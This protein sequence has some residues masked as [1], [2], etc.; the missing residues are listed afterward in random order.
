MYKINLK[1]LESTNLVALDTMYLG[2]FIKDKLPRAMDFYSQRVS[3]FKP[4]DFNDPFSKALSVCINEVY[5][6]NEQP[7]IRNVVDTMSQKDWFGKS[8]LSI[9]MD[10]YDYLNKIVSYISSRGAMTIKEFRSRERAMEDAKRSKLLAPDNLNKVIAEIMQSPGTSVDHAI[11]IK[12]YMDDMVGGTEFANKTAD[13]EEQKHLLETLPSEFAKMIGKPRFTF[14][15]HWKLNEFIPVLRPGEKCVMPGCTGEGKSVCAMMFS[16]W[17]AICGK[18]VLVIHMEDSDQTIL[19]RQTVRWIGGTFLELER[20]DPKHR[21]EQM[22]KLR[23]WWNTRGGSLT[24][25]YLAG[26]NIGLIV[27]QIKETAATLEAEDKHLDVVVFDYFQKI[28]FDSGVGSGGNYVNQATA[29]A[30]SLKILA[31]RLKLFMFV[32]SQETPD[33]NGGE[34]ST[35]GKR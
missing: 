2:S 5:Q 32:V 20:G 23:E 22:I 4:Q 26:N 13:W 3:I 30:E 9:D 8:G 16:E 6:K 24:Y 7:T 25:K 12:R 17:A 10:N 1:E 21:M 34:Q 33:A 27:E 14:P 19:M 29:G 28:D 11:S 15:P 18:N 35:Y 31:E